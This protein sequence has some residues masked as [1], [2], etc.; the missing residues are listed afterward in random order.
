MSKATLDD[1]K[2]KL[3]N[4]MEELEQLNPDTIELS[5]IDRLITLINE[6]DDE[7]TAVKSN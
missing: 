7:I 2:S 3:E 4:F 6:L 1:V 5:Q